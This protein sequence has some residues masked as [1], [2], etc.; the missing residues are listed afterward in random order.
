MGIDFI[1]TIRKEQVPREAHT[2]KP[3]YSFFFLGAAM[4]PVDFGAR[5]S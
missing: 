5:Q 3:S 1:G 4:Y 2:H